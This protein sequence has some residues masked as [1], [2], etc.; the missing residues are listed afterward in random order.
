M[1]V[2]DELME[3]R[4][5]IPR[6]GRVVEVNRAHPPYAMLDAA[7]AEVEPV[8]AFLRDLALGD[9]SPLTCRSYGYGMLR[10]F[11]LL[12]LLGTGWERATESEVAVLTGWLRSAANPQR[13]R[14][15]ADAPVAG[16]V[17]LRTGKA[18]L[19]AGYAPRT[20]N[21]A[22][23]VI[24]G[25]YE[26]HAHQGRGPV[27]NP[28]P[29]SAQRRRALGHRSPLEPTP[30]VGRARLRQ[31]VSDRSPRSIP[32]RLWDELFT[33]MN[34]DRDRA[35][36]E[37]FVSSGARAKELLGITVSDID[38][39]GQRI[40]VITKGT[41]ARE[42][43]PVSPQGL[44]RLALYLDEAGTPADGGPLWRARRGPDRPLTYWAMRRV[45]Q[46]ANTLLG[47]N[48]SLHD[49]RHTAAYRMANGGKLT[50]P[51]V[52]TIMRH[53]D[54]QTT[55]RYLAVHIEELFDKLTEHYATPRPARHYPAG[56]AAADIEAVFG[57]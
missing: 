7:G 14:Q 18:S 30:V 3:G 29:H 48:W 5:A 38:W 10:W 17:N 27:V 32:D 37:I 6:L 2:H 12:W 8:T 36:L 1:G 46:R 33:A 45:M 34:C 31:R 9:S 51:E 53:A 49:L 26:F 24:S 57:A 21:H 13:Q 43:V 19:C 11:R 20:I 52:Q 22:L 40:Y 56:Y 25:F 16:T 44:F 41:R 50:L 42:A 23:T 28:V 4:G 35:L 15:R 39:S 54:I 47:T 55:N